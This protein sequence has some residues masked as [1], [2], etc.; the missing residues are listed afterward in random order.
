MAVLGAKQGKGWYDD[1]LNELGFK[2][3]SY[4]ERL[5]L[6]DLP[7]LELRRLHID[8]IWCYKIIFGLVHIN[9]EEFFRFNK[10]STRGH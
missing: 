6:L 3:L 4:M 9:C 8:L 10:K 2:K 1:Y 5:H 7:S